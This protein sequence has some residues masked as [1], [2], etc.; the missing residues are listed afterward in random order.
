M[1][2]NDSAVVVTGAAR[3]AI[4]SFQG[5]LATVAAPGLGAR[6]IEAILSPLRS[7]RNWMPSS[8]PNWPHPR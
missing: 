3:T 5:V 2:S 8:K 4:G 6:A 1:T 7:K